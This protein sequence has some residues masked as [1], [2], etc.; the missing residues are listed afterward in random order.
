MKYNAF[1]LSV[2]L[3]FSTGNVLA[4]NVDV[5]SSPSALHEEKMLKYGMDDIPSL[6]SD[7]G[8]DSIFNASGIFDIF[9]KFAASIPS[10]DLLCGYSTKDVLSWYGVDSDYDYDI[11]VQVDY[12]LD[13]DFLKGGQEFFSNLD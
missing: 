3:C 5:C 4:A 6:I 8:L 12:D 13:A 1:L 11:G 10:A 7:C 2:G 9:D